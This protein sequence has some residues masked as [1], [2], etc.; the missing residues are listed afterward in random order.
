V[1]EPAAI[2]LAQTGQ[3]N[4]NPQNF[5]K[6]RSLL[7]LYPVIR[8]I[9][10]PRPASHFARVCALGITEVSRGITGCP[11]EPEGI[12]GSKVTRKRVK[13]APVHQ[14]FLNAKCRY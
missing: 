7:F 5:T 11:S 13:A 8:A 1:N 2:I 12:T 14:R 3:E 6:Q 10:Q 9:R 4:D